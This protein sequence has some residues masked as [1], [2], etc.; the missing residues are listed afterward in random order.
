LSRAR[1]VCRGTESASARANPILLRAPVA[2]TEAPL[3]EV[4]V[5]GDHRSDR[6]FLEAS[7][8]FQAG[9]AHLNQHSQPSARGCPFAIPRPS[10]AERGARFMGARSLRV[11]RKRCSVINDGLSEINGAF[12]VPPPRKS[13][14]RNDNPESREA[15]TGVSVVCKQRL[16]SIIVIGSRSI[17]VTSLTSMS[18]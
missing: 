7:A 9:G 18:R 11:D 1:R 4:T 13:R 17:N 16:P 2:S 8:C 10:C 6:R 15:A 12:P 3:R 5:V 14:E